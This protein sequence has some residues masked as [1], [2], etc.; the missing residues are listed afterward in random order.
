[1][2]NPQD[3]FNR[4]QE[5]KKKKK[6]VQSAFRD[7]LTNLAD[8]QDITEKIKE[9]QQKKKEIQQGV[10]K[11][12]ELDLAKLDR[13]KKEIMEETDRL[14]AMALVSLAKGEA[15][16]IVD[17]QDIAYDPILT[18]RFKKSETQTA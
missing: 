8:Y 3:S 15:I 5:A 6:E 9:L 1:M 16:L 4:I 12:F 13:L 14:S 2:Q 11:Q 7:A 17:K 18:V 10:K